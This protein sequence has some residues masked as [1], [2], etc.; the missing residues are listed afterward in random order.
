MLLGFDMFV[1]GIVLVEVVGVSGWRG[2][3]GLSMGRGKV[4]MEGEVNRY[5]RLVSEPP[6]SSSILLSFRFTPYTVLY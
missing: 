5:R 1:V 4:G 6:I 3:K 2:W